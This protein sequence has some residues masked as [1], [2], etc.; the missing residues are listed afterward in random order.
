MYLRA[1][2]IEVGKAKVPVEPRTCRPPDLAINQKPTRFRV[3]AQHP[4]LRPVGVGCVKVLF[5]PEPTLALHPESRPEP[6]KTAY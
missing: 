3:V 2:P 6:P 5:T 4:R 1:A